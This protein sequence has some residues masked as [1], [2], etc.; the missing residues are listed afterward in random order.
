MKEVYLATTNAWKVEIAKRVIEG[1]YRVTVKP[2]D[3][4]VA[5]LQH[6]D[7]IVIARTSVEDAYRVLGAPVIKCDVGIWIIGLNGFP[8]PYSSYVQRT[9]SVDDLLRL[10]D[11][12]EDRRATIYSVVAF[13]DGR[14]RPVTF[15]GELPGTLLREKRGRHG[16]FFDFIFV[17]AG[18]D[19]A[20]AE[21][22]DSE[23]WTFWRDAYERFAR[24]YVGGG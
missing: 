2:R 23:R 1:Q 24:W 14:P 7:P 17:P 15:C 16:Y 10:C 11:P 5:E 12:L 13:S 6:D 9:L 8:G 20:L 19:R 21:F 4:E 22:D 18:S 3:L